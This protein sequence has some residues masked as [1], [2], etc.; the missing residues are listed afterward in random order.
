MIPANADGANVF[1]VSRLIDEVMLGGSVPI[2]LAGIGIVNPVPGIVIMGVEPE[3][4]AGDEP[5]GAR[6]P[7]A[8]THAASGTCM[9]PTRSGLLLTGSRQSAPTDDPP[10][11]KTTAAVVKKLTRTA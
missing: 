6:T 8:S 2:K 7:P 3:P 1:K 9:P 10:L 5:P 4:G 11:A